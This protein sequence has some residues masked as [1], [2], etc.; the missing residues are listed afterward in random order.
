MK[1]ISLPLLLLLLTLTGCSTF[2]KEWKAASNPPSSI[3]GRWSGQW[4]SEKNNHHGSLR[5]IITQTSPDTY[6]AH[7]RA[8]YMKILR[9]TYIAT[10]HATEPNT[11][12]T[13]QL[14]TLQG[15]ANL[16]KL[17]G[18]IYTYKATASPTQFRSTYKSKYDHGHY[19]MIRPKN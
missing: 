14:I 1:Y 11:N 17:A 3:E 19:E 13:Q 7:Y 15:Q 2:H 4:R 9:F 6:R 18:G 10:L 12:K 8:K 5:A 16:G